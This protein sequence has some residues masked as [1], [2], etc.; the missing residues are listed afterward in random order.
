VK[1]SDEV[2]HTFACIEFAEGR[3]LDHVNAKRAARGLFGSI[4]ELE[5]NN[6]FIGPVG[7]RTAA[8]PALT[9]HLRYK[10]RYSWTSTDF[11]TPPIS[12]LA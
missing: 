4:I 2:G 12:A 8:T 3:Y 10:S 11:F 7:Y 1:R 5:V 6:R 9:V